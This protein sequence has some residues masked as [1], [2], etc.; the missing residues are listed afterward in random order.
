[1]SLVSQRLSYGVSALALVLFLWGFHGQMHKSALPD[2]FAREDLTYPVQVEDITAGTPEEVRFLAEGWALDSTIHIQTSTGQERAVALVRAETTSYLLITFLSGL[3]FWSVGAFVFAPR[4]GRPGVFAFFWICLLYGLAIMIGG[5]YF[6]RDPSSLRALFGLLQLACLGFLPPMFIYL[7][8]TFPH[9]SYVL[10]R[11]R[12]LMP[13]LWLIATAVVVWQGWVFIRYFL[14]PGPDLAA[15]LILPQTVADTLMVIQVLV[16]ISI[17]YWRYRGLELTREKQQVKWLFLGF[18]VGAGPY[19]FLRTLP[20]LMGLPT[21]LSADVDRILELAIP[22]SFMFAVV[23]YQFLDIDVIIRRGVLYAILAAGLLIVFLLPSFT[24]VQRMETGTAGQ[25]WLLLIVIGLIA[26]IAFQPLRR[27]I[28][29]WVDR[30]FFKIEHGLGRAQQELAAR[31]DRTSSQTEVAQ[32]A[33]RAI[34]EALKPQLHFVLVYEGDHVQ[35]AGSDP[36]PTG[37]NWLQLWEREYGGASKTIAA[38]QSTSLPEIES[39]AFPADLRDSGIVLMEPI[40]REG[41]CSGAILLGQR[42]TERR[43]IEPDIRFVRRCATLMATASERIRLVQTVAE[44]AMARRRLD[45][46]NQLKSDFLSHVAHDLRTPLASI[47]WSAENLLDGVAGDLEPKQAE[48]LGSIKTSA[49]HLNR[50]VGGLLEI[51]RLERG[52]LRIESERVDMVAVLRQAV[53][54]VRPVA[55]SQQ[56]NLVMQAGDDAPP[57][58]GDAEKLGEVAINLLENAVKFSPPDSEVVIGLVPAGEDQLEF[59]VRD[60]GPGLTREARATLYTRFQQGSPSPYSQQHGFGLGL[61]IV[62]SYLEL[63]GGQVEAGNHPEGGAVFTCRLQ[64]YDPEK[65]SE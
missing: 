23:R 6:T 59:N 49:G 22:T 26:G 24:I 52:V 45:E 55:E 11:L 63:M 40:C 48:Y 62:K 25:D 38:P 34:N 61:Y 47:S 13:V 41:A 20:L 65:G 37:N 10:D 28:G 5:I 56:V 36:A 50:L 2:D 33:A 27:L 18:A 29:F 15:A 17:L 60:H 9:R 14:A 53:I 64:V 3:F 19:V 44:E 12:W 43:Y 32:L 7:V 51:S 30:T 16:G 21:L 39:E 8:L 35:T 31:L 58:R 4:I 57:V 42:V 54:T 1:M 46:L